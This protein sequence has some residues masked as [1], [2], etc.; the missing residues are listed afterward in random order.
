MV[1]AFTVGPTEFGKPDPITEEHED[2]RLLN[3]IVTY[4]NIHTLFTV[5]HIPDSDQNYA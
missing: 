3:I 4:V 2:A 5:R 1:G